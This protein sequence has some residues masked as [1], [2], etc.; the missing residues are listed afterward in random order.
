MHYTGSGLVAALATTVSAH[1]YVSS[2]PARQA[3]NA[4]TAACG[5]AVADSIRADNTSHVE[6]LPELAANDAGY[7]AASCD[8]WLCRGIQLDDNVANI[9]SYSPGQTVNIEIK[10]TIPHEGNANVSIVD[11]A[12]NRI[13]GS[14]L[15]Q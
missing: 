10:L 1:G 8:L 7:H 6:G 13:V 9:Q 2:P 14:P 15:V 5:S 12:T 4:T 11:T 3:N